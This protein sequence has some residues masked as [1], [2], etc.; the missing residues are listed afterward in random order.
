M[1]TPQERIARGAAWLDA[2]VPNWI[3]RIDLQTLNLWSP[4]RCVLGQVFG[5]ADREQ[6][7]YRSGYG[8][9]RELLV[10]S[11]TAPDTHRIMHNHAFAGVET[12][13][14]CDFIRARRGQAIIEQQLGTTS[15]HPA[16]PELEPVHAEL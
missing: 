6:G 4:W 15:E 9:G 1:E 2:T 13:E 12:P 8:H 16:A 7:Y 3:D 11:R 14:W 10:G 5:P